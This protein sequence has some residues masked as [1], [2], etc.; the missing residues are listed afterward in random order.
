LGRVRSDARAGEAGNRESQNWWHRFLESFEPKFAVA[1]LLVAIQAIVI[2]SLVTRTEEA[3]FSEVRSPAIMSGSPSAVFRV[4]F[5]ANTSERDI[6]LLLTMTGAQ[7][8]GGPTQLGDYYLAFPDGEHA[9]RV[10]ALQ[11]SKLLDS[12]ERLALL[13]SNGGNQ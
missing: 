5:Q 9:R 12:F 10:V 13:P 8:I 11:S 3:K 1:A 2:G 6:R 7:I 4:T